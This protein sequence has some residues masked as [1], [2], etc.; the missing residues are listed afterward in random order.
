MDASFEQIILDRLDKDGHGGAPWSDLVLAAC[1]GAEELHAALRG[2]E[3]R[4]PRPAAPMASDATADN[5]EPPGAYLASITVEGFRGIGPKAALTFTPG[6]GLTLVVGR[7]GSGKSSFAEALELLLTGTNR[8]WDGR[9]SVWTDGWRSLHRPDACAIHAEFTAEGRGIVTVERTWPAGAALDAGTTVCQAK[10]KPREPYTMLGW[11]AAMSMYRP[12]LPYSELSD[13]FDK[14][15]EI[16]DALAKILGLDDLNEVHGLL[17]EARKAEQAPVDD[18]NDRLKALLPRLEAAADDARAAACARALKPRKRDLAAVGAVLD[19]E[20]TVTADPAVALLRR[21]HVTSPD[22]DAVAQAARAL[23]AA[24]VAVAALASTDASRARELAQLLDQALRFHAAHTDANCPV[25]G[26]P[27]RLGDVWKAATT[28]QVAALRLQA[29]EADA[30]HRRLQAAVDAARR[31]LAVPLQTLHELGG[32]GLSTAAA[33]VDAVERWNSGAGLS[34]PKELAAQLLREM[35]PLRTALAA[36]Q[37]EA[38]AELARRED[39]WQPIAADLRTWLTD[40]TAAEAH[41]DNAARLK[42]ALEWFRDVQADVRQERFQPIANQ[43]IAIWNQ[44]RQ[45]SN[46]SLRAVALEGV[47]KQRHVDLQVAVDDVPGAALGVMSQGELNALALSLFM[48][49]AALPDSPFRFMLIDD[50]VQSMDPSRVDGLARVLESAAK[51]R[52]VIVFTHDDR[53][54]ESVRRL[55]VAATV[56]EVMRK[57]GSVVESRPTMSPV[58]G[59]VQDAHAIRMTATLPD[60]VKR[61]VLPGFC[62]SAIEAACMERIRARRLKKGKTHSEVESLLTD[63]PKLAELVALAVFDDETKTGDVMTAL[64]NKLGPWAGD[65]FKGVNR[66]AHGAFDGDLDDLA[67]SAERLALALRPKA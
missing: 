21:A 49:R 40:A 28:S 12:F 52:Q 33:A 50:P 44:L 42:E 65:A 35:D 39:L 53:L 23:E 62:R 54:P 47:S 61:R 43:A 11:G 9:S 1:I 30:A 27:D 20:R 46:V 55:G 17:Q 56:V 31:L 22:P 8:R 15:S 29:N 6:P 2:S 26:A 10:G 4:V 14:P 19:A 32:L 64:N 34:A 16:Y 3:P 58:L 41:R 63:H 60:D 48:P 18:V 38:E 37:Q 25:C 45:N 13:L 66:G 67:K 59:Y 5:V 7:N 24:D 57:P 36:L 51:R